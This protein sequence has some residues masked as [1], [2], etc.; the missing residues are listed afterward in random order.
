[1]PPWQ[2]SERS[3]LSRERSRPLPAASLYAPPGKTA[4][5]TLS[6]ERSRPLLAGGR[7]SLWAIAEVSTLS[8]GAIPAAASCRVPTA[9]SLGEVSTLSRERS[10]PLLRLGATSEGRHVWF[11]PS[12]GSDPGRCMADGNL[13]RHHNVFQPQP[14]AIP[15]AA[16]GPPVLDVRHRSAVSTLSRERS[17]P[18]LGINQSIVVSSPCCFNPQPG[19]I[20]AA[21][22]NRVFGHQRGHHVSTLSR[23]RSRPLLGSAPSWRR[24]TV[25]PQLAGSDPGRCVKARFGVVVRSADEFQ[26][27]AG[28]DPGRCW[29]PTIQAAPLRKLVS[30]LSRERSRRA[31]SPGGGAPRSAPPRSYRFNPQPGAI[32]AAAR[33]PGAVPEVRDQQFQPLAGSDPGRCWSTCRP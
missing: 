28:S 10:R 19:A 6:R 11:Q 9:P 29:T 5:S 4:V 33:V 15:A 25:N 7:P 23:E 26:P 1:M 18:L 13:H 27:S 2:T 8:R 32:P 16:R 12:A 30:T 14:G 22:F 24:R 31:A 3:T 17:R 20:P 21:A